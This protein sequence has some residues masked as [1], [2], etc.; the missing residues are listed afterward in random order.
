M[1][2]K[3]NFRRA[4]MADFNIIVFIESIIGVYNH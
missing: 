2:L 4:F 1:K 3:V